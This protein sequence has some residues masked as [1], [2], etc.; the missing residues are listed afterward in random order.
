M[1]VGLKKIRYQNQMEKYKKY[2]DTTHFQQKFNSIF[3]TAHREWWIFQ[4]KKNPK[5]IFHVFSSFDIYIILYPFLMR[6]ENIKTFFFQRLVTFVWCVF[7]T[8]LSFYHSIIIQHYMSHSYM[9]HIY[10]KYKETLELKYAA[11]DASLFCCC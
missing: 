11:D 9:F 6:N 3:Y 1:L 8:F 5:Q 7:I 2:L 10:Q 4:R